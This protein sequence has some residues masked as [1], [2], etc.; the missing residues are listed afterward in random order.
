M[1]LLQGNVKSLFFRY[2]AIVYAASLI[3]SI[4]GAVDTAMV[5]WYH[6]PL[7]TAAI[8]VIMPMFS[9]MF[10]FGHLT[11]LGG[12]IRFG[13]ERG[14]GSHTEN[15]YFTIAVLQSLVI[16]VAMT[17]LVAVFEDEL[18]TFMG[19]DEQ[20]FPLAKEYMRTVKP[21]I[22]AFMIG[23]MLSNFLRNDSS[24]GIATAAT[25][26]G[27][28]FNVFGDYYFVFVRDM[29]IAGAGLATA[30]GSYVTLLVTLSHFLLKRNTLRFVPISDAFDKGSKVLA[31]G[32]SA[33]FTDLSAGIITTLFNRQIMKYLGAD[34]L[35]VYGVIGQV[36]MM[37]QC[38]SYSIGS[39]AQPLMSQN[40][41]ARQWGRIKQ[42]LK[43]ALI[44]CAAVSAVWMIL[45][46][47]IP[48]VFI[49]L[50][51]K[52]TDAVL[53]IAPAII[54]TYVTSFLLLMLNVFSTYYF[55]SLLQART[56]FAVSVGRGILVSGVMIYLL[57]A[58]TPSL[59]WFAMPIT[60]LVV[61][62]FVIWNIIRYTKDIELC[63]I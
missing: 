32:F 43:Y 27:G 9:I 57:P 23:S 60:E 28:I 50:F 30:I 47:A 34:A 56:S 58:I 31:S 35:A 52:P 41:G 15:Q 11:G 39:A 61:G 22:P 13:T 10:C 33:F 44:T 25:L 37:V 40:F 24:P 42:T 21:A 38:A 46:M 6:G 20:L 63:G 59:I 3:S 2:F 48:N 1:D 8:S 12:S 51:M 29:G 19:A 53:Q 18:I 54:R 26:A 7:G 45:S 14:R 62:I 5:G 55:Q 36:A 17:T 49:K 16:A 4:Y